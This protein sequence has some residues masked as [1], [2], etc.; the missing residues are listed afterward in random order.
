[1]EAATVAYGQRPYG[2]KNHNPISYS[3]V[4]YKCLDGCDIRMGQGIEQLVLLINYQRMDVALC[5]CS[6]APVLLT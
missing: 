4:E 1:M 6:S 3:S 2:L 5:G